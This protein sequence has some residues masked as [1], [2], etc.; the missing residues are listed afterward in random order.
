MVAKGMGY[1]INFLLNASNYTKNAITGVSGA[2]KQ[3]GTQVQQTN[4]QATNLNNQLAKTQS[5]WKNIAKGNIAA[6]LANQVISISRNMA[7]GFVQTNAEFENLLARLRVTT[8]STEEAAKAFRD[9]QKFAME[10]PS[11]VDQ[12]TQAYIKMASR[13]LKPSISSLRELGDIASVLGTRITGM[14]GGILQVVEAVS[15]LVVGQT[16][17]FEELGISVKSMGDK[18]AFTFDGITTHVKRDSD[19]IL[20]YVRSTIGGAFS[21][22]MEEQMRTLAGQFSVLTD[23]AKF[24]FYSVGRSGI[25]DEMRRTLGIFIEMMTNGQ[26]S[27]EKFSDAM[28]IGLKGVNFVIQLVADHARL[29]SSVLAGIGFK[30]AITGFV[31]L[32][33]AAKAFFVALSVANPVALIATNLGILAGTLVYFQDN[34]RDYFDAN[35]NQLKIAKD[36]ARAFE[37]QAYS[38]E[39][40]FAKYQ[41]LASVDFKNRFQTD[42]L[43]AVS[44]QLKNLV[45]GFDA[46]VAGMDRTTQ[47][48]AENVQ[49]VQKTLEEMNQV[50]LGAQQEATD[51]E[52]KQLETK[53]ADLQKQLDE[54]QKLRSGSIIRETQPV[55]AMPGVSTLKEVVP[56][57]TEIDK[58][59]QNLIRSIDETDYR[60][61]V[62]SRS[63]ESLPVRTLKELTEEFNN[64]SRAVLKGREGLEIYRGQIGSLSEYIAGLSM[65][66]KDIADV[67]FVRRMVEANSP[68][69]WQPVLRNLQEQIKLS[70]ARNDEEREWLDISNKEIQRIKEMG[71]DVDKLGKKFWEAFGADAKN[72]DPQKILGLFDHYKKGTDEASKAFRDL[73]INVDDV[74]KKI[75]DSLGL[76]TTEPDREAI[77]MFLDYKKGAEEAAKAFQQLKTARADQGIRGR[78]EDLK[79]EIN[80]MKQIIGTSSTEIKIQE[81]VANKLKGTK[82]ASNEAVEELKKYTEEHARL[83]KQLDET[84][85]ALDF[86]QQTDENIENLQIQLEALRKVGTGQVLTATEIADVMKLR[87]QGMDEEANTLE[88]LLFDIHAAEEAY[89][90]QQKSVEQLQRAEESLS[91][92]LQTT[93]KDLRE[94]LE[95]AK[96]GS[97]A[98]KEWLG[99]Q[100]QLTEKLKEAGKDLAAYVGVFQ[101]FKSVLTE[102]K[103]TEALNEAVQRYEDTLRNLN[104]RYDENLALIQQGVKA[105]STFAAQVVRLRLE[106]EAAGKSIEEI[107]QQVEILRDKF[108]RIELT[109]IAWE[110][111]ELKLHTADEAR[112]IG[113]SARERE[114]L[115]A[116]I[117]AETIY[118]KRNRAVQQEA[119]EDIV[120]EIRKLQELQ[121]AYQT[122]Y[123]GMRSALVLYQEETNK[124]ADLMEGATLRALDSMADKLTE[125]VSTGKLQ[126]K[127]FVKS[128]VDDLL[129]I[130][131]QRFVVN[132]LAGILDSLIPSIAGAFGGIG[133]ASG[134]TG[135]GG[136]AAVSQGNYQA[137]GSMGFRSAPSPNMVTPKITAQTDENIVKWGDIGLGEEN[138]NQPI[139]KGLSSM[140]FKPVIS[141][142]INVDSKIPD[143]SYKASLSLMSKLVEEMYKKQKQY[144]ENQPKVEKRIFQKN[145]YEEKQ[146]KVEKQ[147]FQ[148]NQQEE[149]QPKVETRIFQKNQIVQKELN[150]VRDAELIKGLTDKSK[151]LEN[152]YS[153]L[154]LFADWAAK[155]VERMGDKYLRPDLGAV[156]KQQTEQ[157]QMLDSMRYY[158]YDP[159]VVSRKQPFQPDNREID[160]SRMGDQMRNY[161]SPVR[162]ISPVRSTE[163]PVSVS[164]QQT[165]TFHISSTDGQVDMR[166]MEL[167]LREA[168]NRAVN[169]VV[170]E[171]GRGGGRVV[172]GVERVSEGR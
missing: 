88:K 95:E 118:R 82:D 13:G 20:K 139:I 32:A 66:N 6:S 14:Q 147:I 70:G 165:N 138:Q 5:L 166:Q 150:Q 21:G 101:E 142:V 161:L 167:V 48:Y 57:V 43:N 134:G 64:I 75:A 33:G 109:E 49:L 54:L 19:S 3:L 76:K 121:D 41:N 132:P 122:A 52:I 60:I 90:E 102:I 10:T 106:G 100:R 2:F 53:R 141:P 55:F 140:V 93:R 163:N 86:K 156:K 62:L 35:R 92:F 137:P 171:L 22:A 50:A 107:S 27:A 30:A 72:V 9:I 68:E 7:K 151:I 98:D 65:E 104:E 123:N 124:A 91:D 67:D 152:L 15:D 105:G 8:G 4:A 113:L 96:L 148:K 89:R 149:K 157:E 71:I 97:E 153:S 119:V 116:R 58:E 133:G 37:D 143:E 127:E 103:N 59:I 38:L 25:N 130:Q 24:F 51:L 80:E 81:E 169:R 77:E 74:N 117:Q 159:K 162:E 158:S 164:I 44:R 69:M 108:E 42:L 11:T 128:V 23:S 126:F 40:L 61:Q 45:E 115:G 170:K 31:R 120:N 110:M 85:K 1:A 26:K 16:R 129:K 17:R 144:G 99:I 111:E 56:E 47:A 34:I 36:T 172:R 73:G 78:V 63:F 114:L 94:R 131:M 135:G 84:R 83:K 125:F 39:S 146:P 136:T 28:T 154:G 155:S 112:Y 79:A 29:L 46:S 145:Q 12:V 160:T 87:R 168:E 18:I